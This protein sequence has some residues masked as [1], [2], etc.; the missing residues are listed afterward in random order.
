[1]NNLDLDLDFLIPGLDI[2]KIFIVSV[3]SLMQKKYLVISV[4]NMFPI[5]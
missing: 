5:A 2:M 3:M 1:M 4:F